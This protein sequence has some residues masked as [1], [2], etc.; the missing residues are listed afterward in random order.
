[1]TIKEIFKNHE[2]GKSKQHLIL[3]FKFLHFYA[4]FPT[5]GYPGYEDSHYD[6]AS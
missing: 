3:T 1:M 2:K 6:C 5:V 4:I